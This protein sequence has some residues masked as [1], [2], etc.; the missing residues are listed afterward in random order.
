MAVNYCIN[1]GEKLDEHATHCVACGEAVPAADSDLHDAALSGASSAGADSSAVESDSEPTSSESNSEDF[2]TYA[3]LSGFDVFVIDPN[4]SPSKPPADTSGAHDPLPPIVT[5]QT[6]GEYRAY[7]LEPERMSG[8]AKLATGVV[9]VMLAAACIGLFA[10]PLLRNGLPDFGTSS[11]TSDSSG[12]SAVPE[13]STVRASGASGV[14]GVSD[15]YASVDEDVAFEQL[16]RH[17][18]NLQS[19]NE[20]IASCIQTYNSLYLSS[21]KN[22]RS[23][24]AT[25]ATTLKGEIEQDMRDL[26]SL[27]IGP[28]SS[29]YDDAQLIAR[30]QND[31]LQR[32]AVLVESWDISLKYSTPYDHQDEILEPLRRDVGASG[33]ST[34]LEDFDNLYWDNRPTR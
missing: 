21:D 5:P 2:S 29:L 12:E 32:I 26:K 28:A 14:A 25:I 17:Y 4:A 13:A 7:E 16:L 10:A 18:D 24:A 15:T 9:A 19:Y 23:A 11:S 8:A 3:D 31:Q 1:C 30:L 20:R 22:Q 34:Y 27:G 6:A 33:V